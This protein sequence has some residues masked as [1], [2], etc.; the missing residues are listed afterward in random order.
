MKNDSVQYALRIP[1]ETNARMRVRARH[2]R[3]NL[4][5]FIVLAIERYLDFPDV[6]QLGIPSALARASSQAN[7]SVGVD[8]ASS[9]ST[10]RP[11]P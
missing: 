3:R 2:D 7:G 8:G 10:S 5:Q 11:P 4:N 1:A 9:L 6:P